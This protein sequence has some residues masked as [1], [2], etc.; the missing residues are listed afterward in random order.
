MVYGELVGW[1]GKKPIQPGYTYACAPGTNRVYVYRVATVNKRGV[2][3]DLSWE[4]V[5]RFCVDRGLDHVAELYSGP[6]CDRYGQPDVDVQQW[7]DR[8]LY[9]D[10]FEAVPLSPDSPCDEGVCVRVEGL[11]VV[12]L[13]AKSPVFLGHET[14][15]LDR[16]ELNIEQLVSSENGGPGV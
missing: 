15:Q 4:A 16:G 14:K 1:A 6:L 2:A 11:P 3:A 10:E 9:D 5:K 13:K 8:R 7:L 12:I